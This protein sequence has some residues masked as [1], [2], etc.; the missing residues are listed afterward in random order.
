MLW[1]R[2]TSTLRF[3]RRRESERLLVSRREDTWVDTTTFHFCCNVC[4]KYDEVSGMNT[5]RLS[6]VHSWRLCASAFC[7]LDLGRRFALCSVLKTRL[8]TIYYSLIR[9][10]CGL[11]ISKSRVKHRMTMRVVALLGFWRECGH[12]SSN[13]TC[14]IF[15]VVLPVFI[16]NFL[17]PL[18]LWTAPFGLFVSNLH[19]AAR[20]RRNRQINDRRTE[21]WM[22]F[23][24]E[25]EETQ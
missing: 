24:E 3:F 15:S 23:T 9:V 14:R 4:V 11:I 16:T 25:Q 12:L 10:S 1:E 5:Y 19:A 8:R 7:F 21:E 22:R 2:N 18:I 13:L 20:R 6:S 17:P